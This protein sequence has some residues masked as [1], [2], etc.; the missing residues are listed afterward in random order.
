MPSCVIFPRVCPPIGGL[1]RAS[2]TAV[3]WK[4]RRCRRRVTCN[5]SYMT[6]PCEGA[7]SVCPIST[8]SP[9]SGIRYL[10]IWSGLS[11]LVSSNKQ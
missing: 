4:E 6:P 8:G 5:H 7:G 11:S 10:L 3:T 2:S 9:L 1:G